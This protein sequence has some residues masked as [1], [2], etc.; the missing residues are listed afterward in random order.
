MFMLTFSVDEDIK[1]IYEISYILG[2]KVEIQPLRKSKLIP[3][4]K[5]CQAYGHTQKY[6]CRDP[7]CVKCTGKHHTKDCKKPESAKPKCIHCGEAH[8]ANYRGCIVAIE[9]QNI[10]NGSAN[11]RK[12]NVPQL[13]TSKA[14]GQNGSMDMI[15]TRRTESL[16][17]VEKKTYAQAVA[18]V[19]NHK[20][21]NKQQ[22]D[23]INEI[24][25]TILAKLDKQE[26]LIVVLDERLRKLE[27]SNKGLY[28]KRNRNE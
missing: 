9:L 28:P 17:N 24:L 21:D 16:Q 4:C 6:C 2:C 23:G 25:N 3:Q 27:Y 12:T 26:A 10:R 1:R 14:S 7:R 5:Q 20:E 18:N 11:M 13:Q 19:N 8:P 22:N 15:G